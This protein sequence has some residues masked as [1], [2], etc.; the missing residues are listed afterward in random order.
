[1][2]LSNGSG[3]VMCPCTNLQINVNLMAVAIAQRYYRPSVYYSTACSRVIAEQGHH[4]RPDVRR[5]CDYDYS[6]L[7]RCFSIDSTM[8]D[9]EADAVHSI[10]E[11]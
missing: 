2:T 4:E 7:H 5:A 8:L 10:C 1:M 11:L 6:L 3:L 9:A